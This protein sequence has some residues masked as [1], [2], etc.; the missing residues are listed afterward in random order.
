MEY[1]RAPL[2]FVEPKSDSDPNGPHIV[3]ADGHLVAKLFW[4][5]HPP[6]A[7]EAAEQE[8]YRLGEAMARAADQT[9]ELKFTPP[10]LSGE[11]G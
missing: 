2:R 7:T 8:T 4:P 10:P 1:F 11:S 9:T 5:G 3:D 6:E